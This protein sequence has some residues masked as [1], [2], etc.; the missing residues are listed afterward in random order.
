MEN[1]RTLLYISFFMVLFLL[2]TSW[3]QDY[4]PKPEPAAV[5]EVIDK[6]VPGATSV[7]EA[8]ND[9]P[10]ATASAPAISSVAAMPDSTPQHSLVTVTTDKLIVEIDTKGGDFRSI[11]LKDYPQSAT[12]TQPY[13]LMGREDDKFFSAQSGLVSSKSSAPSHHAIYQFAQ[14]SYELGKEKELNVPLMWFG[15][16]GTRVEK[17]YTFKPGSYEISVKHQVTAG[18]AGW[19]GSQYS[20]LVR[21]EPQ[22]KENKFIYTYTG[23]VVYNDEIKY[24]K[25]KFDQMA[26]G[27][28][29][30][31]GGNQ[32]KAGWAAMIQHYFLGAWVPAADESN[33][34]YTRQLAPN[35]YML[36][37]RSGALSLAAGETQSFSRSLV[38]GPKLQDQLEQIA[39][40][41]ELVVDYGWLTIIA[42]PLFWLL[43]VYHSLFSNWGWAIIFLT[44]TIKLAFYKL[45]ETSYRSMAK[46]RKVAPRLKTLKERYGDDRQ[47]MSQAM[48]KMYKEE[49]INPMGGCFPVLV[50][51]PVFIALYWVLLETVEMRNAPF[52]LWIDNLSAKDPYFILPVIMGISMFIQFKLNPTPMDPI[53]VKVFQFMPIVFTIF[54]AFF[55]SGLVLYWVVNNVLSITQ[56]YVITRRIE[57]GEKK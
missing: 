12:E 16:D 56:Q 37:L 23:G 32:F 55:P 44:I 54:F 46:M 52:M 22:S 20:Q 51:I 9:I 21:A 4:G 53:Q 24:E 19:Q 33:F 47:A 57:A 25:I 43:G 48:M 35:R 40:G 18:P 38:V 10:Q 14:S 6:S 29:D 5:S 13:L 28:L 49:K 11:K 42:K 45:S 50:Q 15:E 7:P 17:I 30:I 39:P 41:L 2:W 36:G 8:T 31:E 26:T 27:K 3:Q 34:Y 1:Q